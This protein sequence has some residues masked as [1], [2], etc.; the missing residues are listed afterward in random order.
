MKIG[1]IGVGK[2][3]SAISFGFQR[4]GHEVLQHDIKLETRLKDVLPATLV[5][6]CVPTPSSAD[7]SCNRKLVYDVVRD[8]VGAAYEGLVVIK[9]TVTPGTTDNLQ[10]LYPNLDL[11]FCPEFLRERAAFSDFVENN[12]VCVSGV[13][14]DTDAGLI[15]E[16]HGSLP[17]HFARMRPLEAEFCKYF[18]NTFNAMRVVFAN[19][20]YDVCKS[21]GADY[22]VIKNAVIKR[23]NI[24]DHYLECN[25]QFRAFSG[26]C[27]P[28]DADAFSHYAAVLGVEVD[29][30]DTMISI[31]EKLKG[32]NDVA[33]SEVVKLARRSS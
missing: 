18:C 10:R 31:N 8:L 11:A 13:Y 28:K 16:A 26:S 25:E 2:V 23:N 27:L 33:S 24:D 6:V 4:I 7:G 12:D 1:V 30:I 17:K 22:S 32:K 21:A 5:F 29:L 3:G 14:K 20:F 15:E 19:Q 9:S